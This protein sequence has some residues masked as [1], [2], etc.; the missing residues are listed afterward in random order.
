[1]VVAVNYRLGPLG[2]PQGKE[3]EE[4]GVLNLGLLDV[5]VALE[6]VQANIGT[7]GGD[8]NKVKCFAVACCVYSQAHYV[9][10]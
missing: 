6:W 2:F 7:F 5:K 8:R 9:R 4:D 10:R 3:A 1:M